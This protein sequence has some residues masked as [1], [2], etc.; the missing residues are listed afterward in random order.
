MCATCSDDFVTPGPANLNPEQPVFAPGDRIS[1]SGI[2]RV[3][4]SHHRP[5][6][7]VTLLRNENFPSCLKCGKSV[8][9]QLVRSYPELE[10]KD[11]RVRLYTIPDFD[12]QAA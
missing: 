12:E 9:F 8:R 3:L 1:E 5:C 4:H 11:F 6:H 7:E 2:Y 10:Q